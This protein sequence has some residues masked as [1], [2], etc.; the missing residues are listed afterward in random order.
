MNERKPTASLPSTYTAGMLQSKAYRALS[1]FMTGYLS[2][3]GLSLPEWKV[4]GSLYE[5]RG[6]T[7]T[8]LAE[9]LGVK[10]PIAT[11]LLKSLEAKQLLTRSVDGKDTR[12]VRVEITAE[13]KNL[14]FKLEKML[15][16]EMRLF[17]HDIDHSDLVVYL[18]VLSQLA[19]KV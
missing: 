19:A 17:L 6:L 4:L 14:A 9:A 8:D 15:R 10:L 2:E 7:P 16:Q 18:R 3:F 11:R 13:G 1:N 5:K 12:V